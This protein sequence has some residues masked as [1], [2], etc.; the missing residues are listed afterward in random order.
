MSVKLG[1][2][3]ISIKKPNNAG[4]DYSSELK[5]LTVNYSSQDIIKK[6]NNGEIVSF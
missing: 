4:F 2:F 1:D 5:G 6:Y 3:G